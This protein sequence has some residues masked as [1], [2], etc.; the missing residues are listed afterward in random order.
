MGGTTLHDAMQE[1][2]KSPN[3][4]QLEIL[5]CESLVMWQIVKL[6]SL[7]E[8]G[9][10]ARGAV[11]GPDLLRWRFNFL[12]MIIGLFVAPKVIKQEPFC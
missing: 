6:V 4:C 9:E 1:F 11:L 10:E 5:G 2:S 8:P 12:P 7:I 3:Q